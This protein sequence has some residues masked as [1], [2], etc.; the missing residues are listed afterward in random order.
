MI[1]KVKNEGDGEGFV[2]PANKMKVR[3]RVN[4]RVR[5]RASVRVRLRM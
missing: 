4:V 3:L 1:A 2:D 5:L